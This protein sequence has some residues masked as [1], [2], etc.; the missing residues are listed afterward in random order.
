MAIL[1][2]KDRQI[3]E[4]HGINLENEEKIDLDKC[5]KYGLEFIEGVSVEVEDEDEDEDVD[6]DKDEEDKDKDNRQRG[7]RRRRR[8][9]TDT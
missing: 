4:E 5:K 3:I 8:R 6:K 1:V 9:K 2:I 7:R